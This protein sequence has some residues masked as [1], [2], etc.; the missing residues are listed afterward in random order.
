[1]ATSVSNK[2]NFH[3]INLSAI[4]GDEDFYSRSNEQITK[5]VIEEIS[6]V[7]KVYKGIVISGFP[8]N[9]TQADALQKVGIIPER[10]FLLFN[11][12]PDVRGAYLKKYSEEEAEL[13]MDRN[14]L[15]LKELK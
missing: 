15:E 6:K 3:L 4:F 13:L 5:K 2:F 12:E 11:N 8:N 1:V 10:Y 7:D 9:A 14:L